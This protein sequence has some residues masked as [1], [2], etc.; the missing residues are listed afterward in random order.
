MDVRDQEAMAVIMTRV[1]TWIKSL[2]EESETVRTPDGAVQLEQRVRSEGQ[3]LLGSLLET[4]MQNAVDHQ[5]VDRACPSC[6]QRRRHKGRRPRGLFSSVGAL[7]VEGT[8]W[9]CRRCG[10]QHALDTLAP[11]RFSRPMQELLCLLGTALASFAKA[12]TAAQKLLGVRVSD[13]TIRRLCQHHGGQDE[14]KPVPVAPGSE[15]I[16]SCD[17]TMV[18][19]RQDGWKELRAYQFRYDSIQHGR[20]Y[21]EPAQTFTPRLRQ[22]AV[23]L[24][25]ARASRLFWLADAAAWID[26]GVRQQ[27]P[28]AIRIID[29]WHAW[30]HVHAAGQGIYPDDEDKALQWARRYCDV[31]KNQGARGLQGRLRSLRYDQAS[32]QA[33]LEKL[34]RYLG[35]HADHL[36][37]PRYIEKGYPISSGPM[38]SFCKQLGQ[39][40]KGPGMR[41]N[42]TNVT[43]M[44]T[45]VSLW[46]NNQWDRYW[47][48]VA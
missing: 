19:T 11:D 2:G 38:E 39:R 18:H 32:R 46:T 17:G 48:S 6:G 12:S 16:G 3:A 7:R 5:A 15:V 29:L 27:L 34:R 44:A 40:L 24:G 35:R 25:A 47:Q 14:V 36:D 1:S 37:Y 23:A 26:K 10:G 43:P 4:L 30:Q 13:A 28:Q 22:A 20:A 21:L 31:L 45:L 42:R 33:A 9:H 41:W 8:Y